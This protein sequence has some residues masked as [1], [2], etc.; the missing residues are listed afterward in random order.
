MAAVSSTVSNGTPTVIATYSNI[1]GQKF[2]AGTVSGTLADIILG[3]LPAGQAASASGVVNTVIQLG[4]VTAIAVIGV[5]SF[6]ALG[7]HPAVATYVHAT[8]TG[9]WYL[10][11]CCAAATPASLLLPAKRGAVM[12]A[13]RRAKWLVLAGCSVRAAWN[14][15]AITIKP[16]GRRRA[17]GWPRRTDRRTVQVPPRTRDDHGPDLAFRV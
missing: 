10:T 17:M 5:L 4:S 2:T 1:A 16:P 3:Q 14:C 15:P 12:I 6:Y 11:A 8:R 13:R 9:L 7:Q